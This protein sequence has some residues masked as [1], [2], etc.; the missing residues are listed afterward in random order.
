MFSKSPLRLGNRNPR[1]R[2]STI[3]RDDFNIPEDV[4]MSVT[5]FRIRFCNITFPLKKLLHT[6][7]KKS[8]LF[9]LLIACL[10]FKSKRNYQWLPMK[11]EL[12][13]LEKRK[14]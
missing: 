6:N 3:A 4:T 5:K 13:A 1:H 12:S 7:G 2:F 14:Q 8:F 11:L 9:Y 10:Q